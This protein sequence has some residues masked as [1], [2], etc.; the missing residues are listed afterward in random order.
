MSTTWIYPLFNKSEVFSKFM[1]FK[2]F[3]EK[4]FGL[5]LKILR[6]DGGGEFVNHSMLNFMNLHGILH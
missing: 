2:A 5:P 1:I 4:Q 6:T 3:V